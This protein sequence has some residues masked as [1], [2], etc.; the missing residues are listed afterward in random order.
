MFSY[1]PDQPSSRSGI[2]KL[3]KEATKSLKEY[4]INGKTGDVKIATIHGVQF[5]PV[6]LVPVPGFTT[7]GPA[8]KLQVQWKDTEDYLRVEDVDTAASWLLKQIDSAK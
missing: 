1:N 2:V 8:F 7:P 4:H 5:F 6:R 3:L